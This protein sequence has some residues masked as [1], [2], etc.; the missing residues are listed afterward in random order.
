MLGIPQTA[1]SVHARAAEVPAARQTA[2]G[3]FTPDA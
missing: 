3:A 1:A 2:L